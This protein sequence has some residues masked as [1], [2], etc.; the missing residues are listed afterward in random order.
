MSLAGHL[1]ELRKRIVISA[2][3][4]L[5]AA[6]IGWF[7][8]EPIIQL[9]LH[10][11]DQIAEQRGEDA[12]KLTFEAITAAFDLRMRIAIAIGIMISAPVWLAQIWLF[13]APG[14]NKREVRFALGFFF[15]ATPLFFGG[16]WVGLQIAPHVIELLVGIAP[17]DDRIAT[18]LTASFYYDFIFK[19]VLVV[20]IAFV[21]P[22]F[23]VMLNLLGVLS[24]KSI[25]RGWR[26]AVIGA[27]AFAA[28]TTPAAD[29]TSMVLLASI[30]I[31]LYLAAAG[32]ALLLD[33][34]KSVREKAALTA[35]TP[36]GMSA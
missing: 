32:I 26:V 29:V 22:V 16:A 25:I 18:F 6:V 34:R 9:L 10:P 21:L 17:E 3:A 4:V 8:T 23:L 20:G 1:R 19:L 35:D 13:V 33:R 15:A 2:I 31:V 14:L 12:V 28:A 7:L 24:G 5:V 36:P 11:I 30:L 27:T